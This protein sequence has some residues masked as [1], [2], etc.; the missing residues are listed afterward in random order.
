MERYGKTNPEL[1]LRAKLARCRRLAQEFPEGL[2]AV[3]IRQ[4]E[5]EIQQQLQAI[6]AGKT[7]W[8]M[9]TARSRPR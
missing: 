4:L 9:H 6:E 3:N 1:E 7:L 2:T 5:T 8:P